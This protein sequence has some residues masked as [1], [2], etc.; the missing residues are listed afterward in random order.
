[1]LDWV[2]EREVK[3]RA[4]TGRAYAGLCHRLDCFASGVMVLAKTSKCASR[5]SEQFRCRSVNKIYL[6]LC[7]GQ[8]LEDEALAENYLVREGRLTRASVDGADKR[9]KLSQLCYRLL[10]KGTLANRL[11]ALLEVKLL[12]GFKHQIRYQLSALGLPLWGDSLYG[13]PPAPENVMAI[14][15]FAHKLSF[16]HPIDG[17]RLSFEVQPGPI[18]PFKAFKAF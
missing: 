8:P 7:L 4:L 14:G 16:N 11:S 6:A 2:K 18:W 13:G 10:Q 3:N 12:T 1:M 9:G 5:L 15:L 17:R